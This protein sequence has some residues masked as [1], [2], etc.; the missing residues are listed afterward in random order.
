MVQTLNK[1]WITENH[2]DFEYKKYMLLAYLQHVSDNFTENRLYPYLSDLIDHYRN[3]KH[4]RENKQQ[5]FNSFPGRLNGA[6]LEQF[7]LVYEKLVGDDAVMMEIEQ[8]L[9]F[10]IPELERWLKEGRK[11]YDFV[12]EHTRIVPVGVIPLS[13]DSGY[14]LLRSGLSKDTHV[15]EYHVTIFENPLERYRGIHLDFIA[16]YEKSLMNSYESIKADLLR[17]NRN[18]PNPATFAI[19][20]DMDVPLDATFLP[21]AKRSIVKRIAGAA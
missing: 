8:I 12:E 17:Y 15:Y 1:N 6:D 11:I 13:S 3:L 20:T 4:L 5:L 21:L 2:I 7:R 18:L 10:S 14:L 9:E 19:E 16:T